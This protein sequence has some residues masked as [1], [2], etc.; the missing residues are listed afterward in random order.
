[1][2]HKG[3]NTVWRSFKRSVWRHPE[4]N[5]LGCRIKTIE[6]LT[7]HRNMPQEADYVWK[8]WQQVDDEVEALSNIIIRKKL[9]PKIKFQ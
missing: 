6:N 8:T 1:V 3:C 9:C 2:V 7:A 4:R 5:F